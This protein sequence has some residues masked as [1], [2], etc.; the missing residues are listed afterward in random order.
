ML[1]LCIGNN[2]DICVSREMFATSQCRHIITVQVSD[3]IY[4]DEEVVKRAAETVDPLD[5][6]VNETLAWLARRS[7]VWPDAWFSGRNYSHDRYL[8]SCKN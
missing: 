5:S 3:R 4:L 6:S 2:H 1:Y 8:H 7:V